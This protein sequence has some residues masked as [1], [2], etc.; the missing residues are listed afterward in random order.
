MQG[1]EPF[2]SATVYLGGQEYTTASC[3]PQVVIGHQRSM[4]KRCFETSSGK[5]FLSTAIK[6]ITERW[7][8]LNNTVSKKDLEKDPILLAASLDPRYRKMTFMTTEDGARGS[9]SPFY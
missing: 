7:G 3:L 5:A 9:S 4:Q 2:E 6:G 1:L 8:T